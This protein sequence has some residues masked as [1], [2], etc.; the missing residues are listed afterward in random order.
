MTT[1]YEIDTSSFRYYDK[2]TL[3]L[4]KDLMILKLNNAL[5]MPSC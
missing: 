5:A 2:I 4:T 3:T 1:Q